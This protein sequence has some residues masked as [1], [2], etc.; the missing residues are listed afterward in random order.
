MHYNSRL[1]FEPPLQ[2]YKLGLCTIFNSC[3]FQFL[4]NLRGSHIPHHHWWYTVRCCC[5]VLWL[6]CSWWHRKQR[7]H[8]LQLFLGGLKWLQMQ[9]Q[10]HDPHF[11]RGGTGILYRGHIIRKRFL[12]VITG[13][14]IKIN[15]RLSS[16]FFKHNT[17]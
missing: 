3:F 14:Q 11:A 12:Q 17:I 5:T 2:A 9:P 8:V 15:W 6:F 10:C 16:K 13:Q 7:D 1:H 4:A